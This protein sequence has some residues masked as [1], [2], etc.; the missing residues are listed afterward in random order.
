MFA[1][2][3]KNEQVNTYEVGGE[4][5][6]DD[7]SYTIKEK[8]SSKRE[9][10]KFGI[11]TEIDLPILSLDG[12]SNRQAAYHHELGVIFIFNNTLPY[13]IHHEIIHSIE[14]SQ[15]ITEPLQA[16]YEKALDKINEDSFGSF[17]SFNFR[18]NIHEFIADGYSKEPFIDAL[19]KE[20]LYDEF[21]E[22]SKY[23]LS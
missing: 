21:I 1:E 15:E 8:M 16:V 5:F 20:G 6:I 2:N 18:K 10:E 23:L 14:Y 22:S 11:R 13:S 19:K 3:N 9:A 7:K 17:K 4:V 12:V